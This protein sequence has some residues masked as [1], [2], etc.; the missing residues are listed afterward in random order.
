[1]ETNEL[2]RRRKSV[3]S[4]TGKLSETALRSV[5]DAAQLS[6]VGM[7]KFESVH[8]TVIQNA[9]LDEIDRNAGAAFGDTSKHPLYGAPCLILVS[10]QLGDPAN[11]NVPYSNAAIIAE[12]MALAAIDQKLGSC[13]I[14]GAVRALNTNPDLVAKLN[15]PNGFVPCCGV[16]IGE[17]SD[18]MEIREIPAGRIAVDYIK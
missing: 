11:G 15:L 17:T 18:K 5:L 8:L 10:T 3:R 12:G 7:G 9:L 6:P 14:W 1:M 2:F 13:L 16:I 4:Y